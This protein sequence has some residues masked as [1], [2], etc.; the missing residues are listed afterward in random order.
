VGIGAADRDHAARAFV[1]AEIDESMVTGESRTVR[2]GVG[3]N[4]VA[5]TVATDSGLCVEVTAVGDDTALAG[6]QRLVGEAQNSSSRAH[7][8]VDRA[9]A[10]LLWFALGSAPIAGVRPED[11]AA[12][13]SELQAEG[14]TVAMVGEGDN[15][16]ACAG[17]TDVGIA[18]RAGATVVDGSQRSHGVS[19]GADSCRCEY[20]RWI[21]IDRDDAALDVLS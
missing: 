18:I 21:G 7:R 9:A 17:E 20:R 2:R 1:P 3:D 5:G 15:G 14:L 16:S 10:W 8:L 6:V 13:V 19:V 11:M 12:K 4:V